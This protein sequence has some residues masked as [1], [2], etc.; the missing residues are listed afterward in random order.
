MF[1]YSSTAS[2][3]VRPQPIAPPTMA[4]TIHRADS[5]SRSSAVRTSTASGQA[6]SAVCITVAATTIRSRGSAGI[7]GRFSREA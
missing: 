1:R 3:G 5:P 2:S 6:A 7:S 4:S